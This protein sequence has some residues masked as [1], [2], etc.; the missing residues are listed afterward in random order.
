MEKIAGM[1][2]IPARERTL[3]Q[4]INT[5]IGQVDILYV[6]L[7][8]YKDIPEYLLNNSK[9]NAIISDNYKGDAMKFI[10]ADIPNVVYFSLDDDLLYPNDYVG[11]MISGLNRHGGIVSLHGR[12]Y[13]RPVTS[14]KKM[15]VNYRCLGTVTED[16]RVD[17]GGTGCMAFNTNEFN[18]DVNYFGH[19]NM[20]D[21]YVSKLA[22]ERSIPITVLQHRIGYLKHIDNKYTIWDNTRDCSIQTHILKSFLK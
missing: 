12:N 22:H 6:V 16:V 14:F 15:L 17:L 18:I 13:P 4:V 19:A 2:T 5:I 8:G 3:S 9:I 1:A 7:N 21:V 10:K 11:S 20:A